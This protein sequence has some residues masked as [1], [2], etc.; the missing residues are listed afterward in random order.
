M[1]NKAIFYQFVVYLLPNL[2]QVALIL[3]HLKCAVF[4]HIIP[5]VYVSFISN[6]AIKTWKNFNFA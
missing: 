2:K 4:Y 1:Y 3:I 6:G 5:R